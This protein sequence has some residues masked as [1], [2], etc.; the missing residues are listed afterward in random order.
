MSQPK[1][2]ESSRHHRHHHHHHHTQTKDQEKK[3]LSVSQDLKEDENEFTEKPV[4][5]AELGTTIIRK[6]KPG[7]RGIPGRVADPT[8]LQLFASSYLPAVFSGTAYLAGSNLP[9]AG[10]V[11]NSHGL[12]PISNVGFRTTEPNAIVYELRAEIQVLSAVAGTA[13]IFGNASGP[14]PGIAPFGINVPI[15]G[16]TV[17]LHDILSLQNGINIF[18]RV[19]S[20]SLVL[21]N[22]PSGGVGTLVITAMKPSS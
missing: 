18:V 15:T 6:G 1:P 22:S 11:T 14:L 19:L 21:A 9:I 2:K 3:N 4:L 20:G 10:L 13:V 7:P 5:R 16:G 12:T 8:L 17:V